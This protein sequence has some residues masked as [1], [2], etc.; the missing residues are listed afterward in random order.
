M[1]APTLIFVT[2]SGH[3]HYAPVDNGTEYIRADLHEQEIARLKSAL[4]KARILADT[5]QDLSNAHIE[6]WCSSHTQA[7][8]YILHKIYEALSPSAPAE[9][10]VSP[11]EWREMIGPHSM[12]EAYLPPMGIPIWLYL[13][14]VEQPTVGLREEYEGGWIWAICYS[15][16]YWDKDEQK[17]CANNAEADDIAP[18]H[19]MPLPLPPGFRPT[20]TN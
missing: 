10:E 20:P 17:W 9:Q 3:V 5:D 6:Q 18:S 12:D 1:S 19:W 14:D 13:P 11:G 2:G 7:R 15:H 8:S 16:P 4:E